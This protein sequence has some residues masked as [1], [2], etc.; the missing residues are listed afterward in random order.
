MAFVSAASCGDATTIRALLASKD[1]PASEVNALDKD[2]RTAFHYACLNDDAPLARVLLEDARV[3]VL[4]RTP[5]GDT[6]VHLAALYASIQALR[7]LL[8]DARTLPATLA[9]NK[10]RETPLHLVAGSGDKSAARAAR[11]LLA[12][13][14]ARAAV[15][16]R[17][18]W[19]RTPLDVAYAHGESCTVSVKE[20]FVLGTGDAGLAE[21]VVARA[22]TLKAPEAAAPAPDDETRQQRAV[23]AKAIHGAL[24]GIKGGLKKVDVV[25]KTMF[26]KSEGAVKASAPGS[27][28]GA[29]SSTGKPPG[30]PALSKLVDFPG[31][32]DEIAKMLAE[33][34]VDPAGKDAFGLTALIKFASWNKVDLI[35]LVLDKL[36][37]EEVNAA[38]RDGKTALHWAVEM[39]SVASIERLVACDRVDKEVKDAKGRRPLDI[40]Q[41]AID[42]G[43]GDEHMTRVL[44]RVRGALG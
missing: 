36:S 32:K 7:L 14:T 18:E 33:D 42:K 29:G 10:H 8:A 27:G 16:A 28:T 17:D 21:R 3:D 40:V 19:D 38:D 30:K 43:G 5:R 9:E 11:E 37:R 26:A 23:Q 35:D 1:T 39:A 20:E 4:A 2:G 41:Q 24:A 15:E 12:C 44:E 25:E 22:K 31:D 34:R 6:A 13:A